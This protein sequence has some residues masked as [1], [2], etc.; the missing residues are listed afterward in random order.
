MAKH[1]CGVLATLYLVFGA[2]AFHIFVALPYVPCPAW[3]STALLC[4]EVNTQPVFPG[5]ALIC[6]GI[7]TIEERYGCTLPCFLGICCLVFINVKRTGCISL[8][9]MESSFR[10]C[11]AVHCPL[12]FWLLPH[13]L[14]GVCLPCAETLGRL[15]R[16]MRKI[17]VVVAYGLTNHMISQPV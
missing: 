7:M 3:L 11:A 12:S 14:C 1:A 9:H 5:I 16:C 17:A 4:L 10:R 6:F 13:V 8:R 2:A 15:R